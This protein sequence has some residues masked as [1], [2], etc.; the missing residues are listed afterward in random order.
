MYT[1]QTNI[2]HLQTKSEKSVK[3]M[4]PTV[5]STYPTTDGYRTVRFLALLCPHHRLSH[6][7][8]PRPPKTTGPLGTENRKKK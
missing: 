2:F 1:G 3:P 7:L 8:T 4:L 5:I 6:F